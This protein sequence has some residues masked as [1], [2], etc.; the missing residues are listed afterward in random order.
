ME[1]LY[2]A[3]DY[4]FEVRAGDWD[5]RRIINPVITS[6][7]T[8]SVFNIPEGVFIWGVQAQ[9]NGSATTFSTRTFIIDTTAPNPPVIAEPKDSAAFTS[10]PVTLKWNRKTDSGSSIKD[11]LVISTDKNFKAGTIKLAEITEEQEKSVDINSSGTYYWKVIS[12]DAAGNVSEP[13]ETFLFTVGLS[14][15][16]D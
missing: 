12:K 8:I 1:K 14:G 5:G 16:S 3:S 13:T 2:N 4:R 6:D 15:L 10:W 9:N 7:D 11:S